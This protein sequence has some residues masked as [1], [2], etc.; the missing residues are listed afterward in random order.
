[1]VSVIWRRKKAS[2]TAGGA[3]LMGSSKCQRLNRLPQPIVASFAAARFIHDL[4]WAGSELHRPLM[5]SVNALSEES[6]T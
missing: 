4:R 6:P 3:L 2:T 5:D 1:M